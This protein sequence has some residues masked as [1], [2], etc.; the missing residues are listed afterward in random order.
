MYGI[1]G[2][3]GIMLKKT[4]VYLSTED[5]AL[6]RKKA[7][8]RHV[9]VAEAIRLSIQESCQPKSKEEKDLWD[10][11]DRIWAK[12]EALDS[13]KVESAVD[14]AVQEVRRG[15]KARRHS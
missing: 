9:T 10:S 14:K 3:G 15:K 6:L 8:V 12:T 13:K 1:Y 4:T 5:L 7:T 11:L 2:K